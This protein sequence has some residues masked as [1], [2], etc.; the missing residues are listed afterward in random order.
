ML[1]EKEYTASVNRMRTCSGAQL[2]S[3][4][5]PD[6]QV[7]PL[8]AK[9]SRNVPGL[10]TGTPGFPSTLAKQRNHDLRVV[11]AR[12]S[13]PPFY[14]PMCLKRAWNLLNFKKRT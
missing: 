4:R 5:L 14:L 11:L 12:R 2:A 13:L 1:A 3:F 7:G 6:D 8:I 10:L 9:E